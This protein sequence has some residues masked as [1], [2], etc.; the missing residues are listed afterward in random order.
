MGLYFGFSILTI[1][2]FCV[3]VF[4]KNAADGIIPPAPHRA[5]IYQPIEDSN[6]LHLSELSVPRPPF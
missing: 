3:F 2:E 1:Y 5:H 6:K 4:V